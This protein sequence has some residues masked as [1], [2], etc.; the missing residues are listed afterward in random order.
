[1]TREDWLHRFIAAYQTEANC[2]TEDAEAV[3]AELD[4]SEIDFATDCPVLAAQEAVDED[5][6]DGVLVDEE[7]P[8]A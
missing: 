7:E 3:A 8:V 6:R 1:M 5:V 4:L 2:S